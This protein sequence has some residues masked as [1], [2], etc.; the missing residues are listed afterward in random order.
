MR[1]GYKFVENNQVS[2][3][4]IDQKTEEHEQN[5]GYK[6]I[7]QQ[8]S[9]RESLLVYTKADFYQELHEVLCKCLSKEGKTLGIGS[10]FGEHELLLHLKGFDIVAS[11]I[12]PFATQ[13]I[14]KFFPDFRTC[15][16]DITQEIDDS[17]Y[18]C[19]LIT[20]MEIYFDDEELKSIFHNIHKVLSQ[21]PIGLQKF[22]F[23][24]R[25]NDNWATYLI[26][27]VLL[28]FEAILLN[29]KAFLLKK[30]RYIRK[31]HG[32]RRS[33][34]EI[35]HLLEDSGF[36]LQTLHHAG[37]GV[38]LNYRSVIIQ[39]MPAFVAKL[40]AAIDRKMNLLNNCTVFELLCR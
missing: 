5:M 31:A 14:P 35:L 21:K 24:Q 37:F 4:T 2:H 39:K 27:N 19:V 10:G 30:P 18:D 15:V 16:L 26:D 29:I 38:E 20:G 13:V 12:V 33:R 40:V 8:F 17:T 1:L 23:V 22:V 34:K 32:Y 6:K 9:S 36:V 7:A 11:D 3:S 28:P 25:Y